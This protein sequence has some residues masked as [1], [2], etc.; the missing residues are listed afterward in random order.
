MEINKREYKR[1]NVLRVTG[2][3][4]ASV[5]VQFEE[6]LRQEVEQ[7]HAHLVLEMDGTDY[8]SSAG[9][10]ALISAQKA[11]KGKG[12]AVLLAQPSERVKEVLDLAGL[13]SLFT[14]FGDTEAA[15]GSV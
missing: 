15:I 11:L 12:G 7:G 3:V 5:A 1:A 2:R 14:V 13:E 4:D 10:R 6:A 9:V 8:I